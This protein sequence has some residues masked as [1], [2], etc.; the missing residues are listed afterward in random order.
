MMSSI[1]TGRK[2]ICWPL[3]IAKNR[4][5]QRCTF[6]ARSSCVIFVSLSRMPS[7]S[8][9]KPC[10]IT[11]LLST[12]ARLHKSCDQKLHEV[13]NDKHQLHLYS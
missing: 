4:D 8:C 6:F 9:T 1:Y 5:H 2:H 13:I 3:S 12:A 11:L 7:I 10:F